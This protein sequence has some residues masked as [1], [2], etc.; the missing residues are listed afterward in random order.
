MTEAIDINSTQN[1]VIILKDCTLVGATDWEA[2]DEGLVFID[3]G[4]P[5]T[6]TS[7]IA[8]ATTA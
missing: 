4:A 5:T 2:G 6:G 8:V 7:G 3:G 1:G